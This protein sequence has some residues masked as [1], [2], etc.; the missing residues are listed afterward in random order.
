MIA[1]ITYDKGKFVNFTALTE[2]SNLRLYWL[3]AGGV[4]VHAAKAGWQSNHLPVNR[5]LTD[6]IIFY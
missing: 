1:T 4:V 2:L 3:A 5:F 6:C